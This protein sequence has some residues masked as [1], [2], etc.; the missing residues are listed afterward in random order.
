M[1]EQRS[2]LFDF[3]SSTHKEQRNLYYCS[4]CNEWWLQNNLVPFFYYLRSIKTIRV[5]RK[6]FNEQSLQ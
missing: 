3:T 6:S 2:V 4:V 1:P 5:E